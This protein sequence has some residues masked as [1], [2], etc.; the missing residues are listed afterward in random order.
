MDDIEAE[1]VHPGPQTGKANNLDK[2]L[3]V[4]S[5]INIID[6][7]DFEN[8]E[9]CDESIEDV[10]IEINIE[11]K[12]ENSFDNKDHA[13]SLTFQNQEAS[14][15]LLSDTNSENNSTDEEKYEKKTNEVLDNLETNF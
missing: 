11:D 9:E 3:D 10:K 2:V 8:S 1:E 15:Q 7:A 13:I 6:N 12:L 5:D 4:D 14:T